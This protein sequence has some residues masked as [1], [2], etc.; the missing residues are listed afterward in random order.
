MRT[1]TKATVA[2]AGLILVAVG[3]FT[4][5][6]SPAPDSGIWGTVVVGPLCAGPPRPDCPDDPLPV[7]PLE[8]VANRRI[9]ARTTSS[10]RGEFILRLP[11]GDYVVRPVS[12]NPKV[13]PHATIGSP[14]LDGVSRFVVVQPH[15]FTR[16]TVGYDTGIR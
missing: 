5:W 4:L 16:M 8:V 1:R 10:E 12:F 9:V 13:G 11:P 14:T 2:A 3:V 7:A 6:P 15:A